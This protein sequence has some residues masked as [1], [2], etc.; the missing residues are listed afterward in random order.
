MF[1]IVGIPATI[2]DGFAPY[3]DLFC[4]DPGF[5]HVS[6]YVTGLILCPDKTL[7]GIYDRQVWGEETPPSRRTIG[8]QRFGA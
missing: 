4:R 1:P 6:R 2:R 5:D 7:Q 8:A 3:R